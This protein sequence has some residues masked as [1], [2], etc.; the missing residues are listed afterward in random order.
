MAPEQMC[1]KPVDHA[2]D[3]FAF[4]V[5][6]F[7][8]LAGRHPYPIEGG[9][10]VVATMLVEE[11]FD[12]GDLRPDVPKPLVFLVARCLEKNPRDRPSI[13]ALRLGLEKCRDAVLSR[14]GTLARVYATS[15][16]GSSSGVPSVR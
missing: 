1:G 9:R 15:S 3:V 7:E 2:I 8:A 16:S 13:A 4:G 11:P 14:P 5:M 6:L 10:D 12:L